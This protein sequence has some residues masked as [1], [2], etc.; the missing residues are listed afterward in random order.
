MATYSVTTQT[1]TTSQ[2]RKD[3]V[4]VCDYSGAEKSVTLPAGKYKIECWGAQGI[5][6]SAS[7]SSSFASGYGGYAKGVLDL[8]HEQLF[9]LYVGGK[10]SQ[11]DGG[12]NGGGASYQGSS[13]NDNGPGGGAT[14]ICLTRSAMSTSYKRT[15]RTQESYLSRIIV[16]GGG[17]GGRTSNEHCVGGY[18]PSIKTS[19]DDVA[20][21]MT[22]VSSAVNGQTASFGYGGS[23]TSTTDDQAGGGGGWYGG[24]GKGDNYG[25]G[26][27][28]FVW[29][30]DHASYIPTG[31]TPSEDYQMTDIS[32]IA[33][34]S[35]QPSTS[36]TSTE[37][38]HA[39]NGYIRITILEIHN[40]GM[41]V[42]VNGV[43]RKVKKMYVGV[44]GVARTVS[45]VY[46][47]VNGVARLCYERVKTLLK[48]EYTVESGDLWY[49]CGGG[50]YADITIDTIRSDVQPHTWM[51]DQS[52]TTLRARA[53][54]GVEIGTYS[55]SEV[56]VTEKSTGVWD[57][58]LRYTKSYHAFGNNPSYEVFDSASQAK[59]TITY[60]NIYD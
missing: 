37:T 10:P 59:V 27:S 26:G 49:Y 8:R 43:A 40:F 35:S 3:D 38:G 7:P 9:Y 25:G 6:S 20:G 47:G 12:W 45:K 60:G 55:F 51:I 41:Y 15:I 5:Y 18:A 57:I 14:D 58:K 42:G 21:G 17:G 11:Y 22:G 23:G 52:P 1:I 36:G 44:N 30:K 54:N 28:S 56:I 48:R 13:Y 2:L 39:G 16:A 33:G 53:S 24:Q 4:I 34:N 31:Y 29:S 19:V 32:C 50:A 46:V